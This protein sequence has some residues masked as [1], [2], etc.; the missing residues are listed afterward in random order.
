MKRVSILDFRNKGEGFL[1]VNRLIFIDLVGFNQVKVVELSKEFFLYLFS[2]FLNV[3]EAVSKISLARL[4][5]QYDGE[6]L[7][8]ASGY[9][10]EQSDSVGKTEFI[11]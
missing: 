2:H 6:Y 4:T 1:V 8:A 7:V 10:F 3:L 5:R 11:Q 9:L